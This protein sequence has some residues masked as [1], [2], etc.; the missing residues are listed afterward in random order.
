[1][2]SDG[3]ARD[4]VT[5]GARRSSSL[6]DFSSDG[7]WLVFISMRRNDRDQAGPEMFL[8][9]VDGSARRHLYPELAD[10]DW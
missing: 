1:M 6:P 3:S 9:T 2:H 8:Q 10:A 7:R 5:N 4:R